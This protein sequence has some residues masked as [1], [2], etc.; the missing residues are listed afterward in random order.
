M[1]GFYIAILIVLGMITGQT[2]EKY[3]YEKLIVEKAGLTYRTAMFVRGNPYYVV[4]EHEYVT[5]MLGL[6]DKEGDSNARA[7]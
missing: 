3:F 7:K 6:V 5:Q 2:L 1:V 4:S